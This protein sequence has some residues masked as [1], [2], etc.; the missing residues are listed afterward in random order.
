MKKLIQ[1]TIRLP[2]HVPKIRG[3][4]NYVTVNFYFNLF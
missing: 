2:E 1:K 4:T 3:Q